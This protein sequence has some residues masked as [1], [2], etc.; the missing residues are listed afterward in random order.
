MAKFHGCRAERCGRKLRYHNVSKGVGE[1]TWDNA[2]K[3]QIE[4][5]MNK[6][7]ERPITAEHKVADT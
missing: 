6:E 7:R 1:K 5:H 2:Q 4:D 3:G